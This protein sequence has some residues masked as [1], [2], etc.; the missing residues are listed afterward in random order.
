MK[1]DKG[2]LLAGGNGTRLKPL[3]NL[4]NKHLLRF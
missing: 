4:L 3:T 1:F 2:I